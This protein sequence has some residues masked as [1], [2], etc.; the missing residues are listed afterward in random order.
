MIICT[1]R[2]IYRHSTLVSSYVNTN[3]NAALCLQSLNTS[4]AV[5]ILALRLHLSYF[6]HSESD[7]PIQEAVYIWQHYYTKW[8]IILFTHPFTFV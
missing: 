5:S 3:L 2:Y 1:H 7:I 6:K 8:K 4:H